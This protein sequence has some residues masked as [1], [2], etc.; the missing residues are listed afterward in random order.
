[1]PEEYGLMEARSSELVVLRPAPRRPLRLP[2]MAWM[3]SAR[4]N[5]DAAP[6]DENQG[7]LAA[8]LG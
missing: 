6:A 5:M 1:M 4:A 2:F 8:D 7:Q 3:A